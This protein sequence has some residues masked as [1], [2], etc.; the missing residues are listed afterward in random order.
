MFLFF[1]GQKFDDKKK[2]KK[3]KMK[4]DK[5]RTTNIMMPIGPKVSLV[6]DRQWAN[7]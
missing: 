6:L 7:K 4:M 1:T 5:I 3:K 2:M